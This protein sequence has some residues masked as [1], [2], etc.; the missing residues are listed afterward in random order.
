MLLVA[1]LF[2]Y[3]LAQIQVALRSGD[4]TIDD[5]QARM[6]F[7]GFRDGFA[8]GDAGIAEEFPLFTKGVVRKAYIELRDS[9][10]I[11]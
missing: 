6:N 4:V 2:E 10:E 5:V 1:E 3:V 7:D 11:R 9:K 8:H